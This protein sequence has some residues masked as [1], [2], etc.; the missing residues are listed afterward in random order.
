MKF[1][2]D[3]CFRT[4]S[5]PMLGQHLWPGFL[6]LENWH[7]TPWIPP[8]KNFYQIDVW[9]YPSNKVKLG[10]A[11]WTLFLKNYGVEWMGL[12]FHQTKRD[13]TFWPRPKRYD[14]R[15][16]RD[17]DNQFFAMTEYI[18]TFLQLKKN[19]NLKYCSIDNFLCKI[20]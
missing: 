18:S 5:K 20:R 19:E 8:K 13:T 9:K 3:F 17:L 4:T 12:N 10:K 6:F 14:G 2:S 15:M 11:V 16:Y 1:S 7:V